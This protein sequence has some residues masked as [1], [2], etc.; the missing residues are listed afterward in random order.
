MNNV[1]LLGRLTRDVEVRYT[2]GN[3]PIAVARFTV[4]VDKRIKKDN[5]TANFINCTAFGKTAENINKYFKKGD[6]ICVNGSIETGSYTNKEGVKINTT[7]INVSQFSFCGGNKN[8]T[9]P[10]NNFGINN[11]LPDNLPF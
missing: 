6:M 10:I 8:S 3:E 5:D 11:D 9:E 1:V 4:A 2:Q 7:E